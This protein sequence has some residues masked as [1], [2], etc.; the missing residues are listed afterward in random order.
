[1]SRARI[2][3]LKMESEMTVNERSV[4]QSSSLKRQHEDDANESVD[5]KIAKSEDGKRR[6]GP[7]GRIFTTVLRGDSD[8]VKT[9]LAE[10]EKIASWYCGQIE[11]GDAGQPHG[12]ITFGF[13]N[14]RSV[15]SLRNT[16]PD[17]GNVQ[18]VRNAVQ[19]IKYCTDDNK[20][21]GESFYYG[22]VPQFTKS[23]NA[24]SNELYTEALNKGSYSAALKY[25]EDTDI[26]TFILNY[27]RLAAYFENKFADGDKSK[28][29]L[30]QFNR[31]KFELPKNKTLV[32]IGPTGFGKTQFALAH[33]KHPL[34]VTNKNDWSRFQDGHTDGI[35]LDDVHFNTWQPNT[36]LHTVDVENAVTQDVKY[37][38]VRIPAGI[39]RI[40]CINS[41]TELYPETIASE[42]KAAIARRL[43]IERITAPLFEK[44]NS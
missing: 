21:T 5:E 6:G 30:W 31:P 37:G 39:P 2:Q 43:Q 1:M 27:K 38:S 40:I 23:Q 7:R 19:A 8:E 3:F 28:F 4:A 35:V 15:N 16:L 42:K 32:L 17:G 13:H 10:I 34:R 25:I 33:F 9:K 12:Q 26:T 14:P 20:R 22:D 36:I 24:W 18:L 41:E 29:S 11:T 44:S